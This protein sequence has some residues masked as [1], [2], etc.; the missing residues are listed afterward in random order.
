MDS[1][2]FSSDIEECS[3][4]E[5][6]CGGKQLVKKVPKAKK[7]IKPKSKKVSKPKALK[8]KS[9]KDTKKV[10]YSIIK[11]LKGGVLSEEEEYQ[12]QNIL[13]QDPELNKIYNTE[14]DVIKSINPNK[15]DILDLYKKDFLDQYKKISSELET[16]FEPFEGQLIEESKSQKEQTKLELEKLKEQEK[17][18]KEQEKLEQEQLKNKLEQEKQQITD[19]INISK[20]VYFNQFRDKIG[21]QKDL[22]TLKKKEDKKVEYENEINRLENKKRKSPEDTQKMAH[23]NIQLKELNLDIKLLSKNIDKKDLQLKKLDEDLKLEAEREIEERLRP[24]EEEQQIYQLGF[25]PNYEYQ[26]DEIMNN[27]KDKRSSFFED[28]VNS[29]LRPQYEFLVNQLG[30]QIEFEDFVN[31]RYNDY[32]TILNKSYNKLSKIG[33]DRNFLNSYDKILK[34]YFEQYKIK[35]TLQL[36]KIELEKEKK[37][38]FLEVKRKDLED[39]IKL[40]RPGID[41][42]KLKNIINQIYS[43]KKMSSLPISIQ[44]EIVFSRLDNPEYGLITPDVI[45]KEQQDKNK[46][47]NIESQIQPTFITENLTYNNEK[48]LVPKDRILYKKS[49]KSKPDIVIKS[50]YNARTKKALE[51]VKKQYERMNEEAIKIKKPTKEEMYELIK[52]KPPKVNVLYIEPKIKKHNSSYKDISKDDQKIYNNAMS[53]V[54]KLTSVTEKLRVKMLKLKKTTPT[55]KQL[56]KD[57]TELNKLKM[58]YE[59]LL[60]KLKNKYE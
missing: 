60:N 4:C 19:E 48:E 20:Q 16:Q 3:P 18:L 45:I 23:L 28:F 7:A 46:K 5:E 44:K 54:N 40:Q 56:N 55:Y 49:L 52:L 21:I 2:S 8:P 39:S 51:L 29:I 41:D 47:L 31:S 13:E 43:S 27:I 32:L 38:K 42:E 25:E 14:I 6:K 33:F 59:S 53:N 1:E 22:D 37:F 35:S 10:L 9:K 36:N 24:L 26:L 57:L 15:D 17:N 50:D 34:N 12:I 30:E 11:K 58:H